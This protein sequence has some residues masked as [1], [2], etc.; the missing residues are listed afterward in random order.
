MFF[1]KIDNKLLSLVKTQ[2]SN[3]QVNCFVYAKN[4]Y[5]AKRYLKNQFDKNLKEYPFINAFGLNISI[6]KILSHQ[7]QH[8][9]VRQERNIDMNNETKK[10]YIKPDITM[11]D[12]SLSSSIASTCSRQ[13]LSAQDSCGV[14]ED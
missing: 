14:I 1:H 2:S 6:D 3:Q 7:E 9:K 12:F 10:A 11:V 8:N 13:A 5:Y 4:F